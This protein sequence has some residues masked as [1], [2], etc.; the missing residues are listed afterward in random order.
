MLAQALVKRGL[1]VG[2]MIIKEWSG[3]LA[4]KAK[5]IHIRGSEQSLAALYHSKY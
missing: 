5:A 1:Q 3:L 4:S 2:S